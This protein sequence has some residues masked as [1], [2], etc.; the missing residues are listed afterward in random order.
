MCIP[1]GPRWKHVCDHGWVERTGLQ[2][3]LKGICASWKHMLET[4]TPPTPTPSHSAP[5]QKTFNGASNQNITKGA[6]RT[7]GCN[8]NTNTKYRPRDQI[9]YLVPDDIFMRLHL[10]YWTKSNIKHDWIE[11]KA[12]TFCCDERTWIIVELKLYYYT[13]KQNHFLFCYR[14]IYKIFVHLIW[15]TFIQLQ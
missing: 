15:R 2:L 5:Q 13:D 6:L 8:G 11:C 1:D 10:W 9:L 3:C 7:A 4:T 14:Y 12:T